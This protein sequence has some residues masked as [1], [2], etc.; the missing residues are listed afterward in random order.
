LQAAVQDRLARTFGADSLE[1]ERYK[2]A[3]IF[4][5][6]PHNYAYEVPIQEVQQSLDRSKGRSIALVEQAVQSLEEQIAETGEPAARAVTTAHPRKLFIVHGRD[7]GTKQTVARFVEKLGL[8]AIIL[9]ERPNKGRTIIAKFR[10]ESEGVGFAVVLMTADD[11]GKARDGSD[12]NPRARQNVVFELGFFIGTL[13]L[14]R[15]AAM[16]KGD[17]ERP[18]DFDGVVYIS[19]DQADWTTQLAKELKAAGY[20]FDAGKVLL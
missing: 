16:V 18:S 3:A 12:L 1:Y 13:K 14:E 19:L 9:H 20:E 15:V 11:V 10:E 7:D 6:G 17:I 2:A 5:N 8:E 4:D